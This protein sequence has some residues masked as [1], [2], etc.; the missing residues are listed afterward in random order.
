MRQGWLDRIGVAISSLCLIHCLAVPV[1]AALLP[2]AS[3]AVAMPEW[4][5]MALLSAALPVAAAALWQGWRRHGRISIAALGIAGLSLLG[6]GLAFHEE[7]IATANPA[8]WD[9][10]T[11]SAGAIMLATAHWRNWRLRTAR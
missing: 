7:M 3:R 2:L 4:V 1:T 5:H 6:V 11:T 8:L 10:L 9:R